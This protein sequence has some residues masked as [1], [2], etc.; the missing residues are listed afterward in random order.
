VSEEWCLTA[1]LDGDA[2]EVQGV[3]E[4]L[5]AL[6]EY[7]GSVTHAG[8]LLRVYTSSEPDAARAEE[9]LIGILAETSLGYE[10]WQQR[11]DAEAGEWEEL[12]PEADEST[13]P[14]AEEDEAESTG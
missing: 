9:V 8:A 2:G 11:W 13:D 1:E 3:V 7:Q 14:G 10:V 12:A 6:P 5:G 4:A